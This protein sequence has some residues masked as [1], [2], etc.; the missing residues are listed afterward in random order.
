[1]KVIFLGTPEFACVSLQ[2][3]HDSRH[4]VVAV[5]TQPDKPVG[6]SKLPVATPV[7]ALATKLGIPVYQFEK[8]SRDGVAELQALNA[9]IM[10]TC[11]YGQI[12]SQ[13]VLDIT[14]NGVINVHGSLLPK[15]R[16]AAPIQWTI[17]NGEEYGGITILKSMAG[18][19]DG[20]ILFTKPVKVEECETSTEL[21]ARLS[22]IGA[23]CA[24]EALDIIASGKAV[25]SAQNEAEATKCRML[26]PEMSKIDFTL[27]ATKVAN[28]INGLNMWPVAKCEIAGVKFKLFKA[29]AV[30]CESGQVANVVLSDNK[31]G[32]VV[33]C[34]DGAVE[35]L[36]F[37]PENGKRMTPKAYLNG[38]S[39]AIGSEVKT[40]E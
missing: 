38:K 9:D 2:A 20:P 22:V 32:L 6:R 7:K 24:V 3:I 11:A 28:W 33:K 14:P 37:Q 10:V 25:F 23:T 16:G 39:I 17:I 13:E 26:K 36:E 40:S 5:V 4:Q 12:L 34:G 29:K 30:E 21:F 27:P 15:Y 31:K 35:I 1:M 19:D 8:I 18:L